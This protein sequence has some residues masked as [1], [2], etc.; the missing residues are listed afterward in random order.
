MTGRSWCQYT[1]SVTVVLLWPTSCAI[2]STG[3]RRRTAPRRKSAVTL[4]ASL[5]R[6]DAGHQAEGAA[7]ITPDVRGVHRG[8]E[9]CCEYQA[10]VLPIVG[11]QAAGGLL[12]PLFAQRLDA[13]GQAEPECVETSWSWCRLPSGP[14]ARL[15]HTAGA[16]RIVGGSARYSTP[17]P[18]PSTK[19]RQ[20]WWPCRPRVS[21]GVAPGRVHCGTGRPVGPQVAMPSASERQYQQIGEPCPPTGESA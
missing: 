19:A 16:V 1:S 10:A 7:E 5:P 9:C 18:T 13:L 20:W 2:C 14:T 8:P 6:I 4:A 12:S 21:T 17:L 3:C 11:G 15:R